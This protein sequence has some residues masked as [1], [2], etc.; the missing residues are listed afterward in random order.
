[1]I[2][3][4]RSIMEDKYGV[5]MVYTY[6]DEAKWPAENAEHKMCIRDRQKSLRRRSASIRSFPKS[7]DIFRLSS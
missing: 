6:G 3:F 7:F 2:E 5:K 4:I 1:M